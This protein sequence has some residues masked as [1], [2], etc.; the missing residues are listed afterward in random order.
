MKTH[1]AREKCRR[2]LGLAEFV[3]DLSKTRT[4]MLTDGKEACF[5][6]FSESA[7]VPAHKEVAF[8]TD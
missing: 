1:R 6:G 5:G 8:S 7:L 4:N 2:V 3:D